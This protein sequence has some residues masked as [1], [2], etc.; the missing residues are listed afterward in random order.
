MTHES[1]STEPDEGPGDP[2]AAF[3][4]LVAGVAVYGLLGWGLGTWLHAAYLTPIGILVGAVLGLYMVWARYG[5]IPAPGSKPRQSSTDPPTDSH[6][7]SPTRPD[8][9][10]DDRGETE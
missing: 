9:R 4:Y 7:N 1:P 8:Q 10:R 2:W 3:G 5:R 6:D